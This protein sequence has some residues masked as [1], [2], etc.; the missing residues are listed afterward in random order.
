LKDHC[1]DH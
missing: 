1:C